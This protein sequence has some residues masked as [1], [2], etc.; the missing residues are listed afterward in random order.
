MGSAGSGKS[1]FVKSFGVEERIMDKKALKLE[2]EREKNGMF[3]SLSF[4]IFLS[5]IYE[6]N[7][8]Y[9]YELR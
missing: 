3:S 1:T 6:A 4:D 5:A 2:I 8:R 7:C 9:E